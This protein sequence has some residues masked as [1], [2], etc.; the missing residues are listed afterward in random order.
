MQHIDMCN[1]LSN[2]KDFQMLQGQIDWLHN[3]FPGAVHEC[4]YNVSSFQSLS[5]ILFCIMNPFQS[6]GVVN[7]SIKSR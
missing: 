7:A 3:T 6:F 5:I 4:P 1:V 2:L